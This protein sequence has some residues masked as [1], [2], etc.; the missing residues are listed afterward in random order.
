MQTRGGVVVPKVE[1]WPKNSEPNNLEICWLFQAPCGTFD[2]AHDAH[3]IYALDLISRDIWMWDIWRHMVRLQPWSAW[4]LLMKNNME[5]CKTW[6]SNPGHIPCQSTRLPLKRLVYL[7][8]NITTKY[9]KRKWSVALE[10]RANFK[11]ANQCVPRSHRL[12][13]P[14]NTKH[15]ATV[16]YALFKVS[17]EKIANRS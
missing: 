5:I 7:Y 17:F 15:E 13:H 14:W 2:Q 1:V 4:D 10:T 3:P 16:F 12:H 11:Q 8:I 9:Y 6:G